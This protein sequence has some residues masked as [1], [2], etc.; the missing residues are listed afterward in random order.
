MAN[1]AW[2]WCYAANVKIAFSTSFVFGVGNIALGHFWSL[3]VEEHFY[4][5]WPFLVFYLAP[6]SLAKICIGCVLF[7]PITRMIFWR[8]GFS[9]MGPYVFTTCR[10]DA[11]AMGGLLAILLR[12]PWLKELNHR[13]CV[14]AASSTFALMRWYPFVGR[15][16]NWHTG[17]SNPL[18]ILLT[19]SFSLSSCCSLDSPQGGVI[20]P[21]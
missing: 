16:Q 8:T 1:Q 13:L 3:S 15:S 21:C 10:M 12:G 18:G 6:E 7:A 4:L 9:P 19:L 20:S 5:I 11:L 2:L 14:F 17:P